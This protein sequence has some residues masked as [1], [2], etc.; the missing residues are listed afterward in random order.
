MILPDGN[1]GPGFLRVMDDPPPLRRQ[2]T[3]DFALRVGTIVRQYAPTDDQNITRATWEYDVEAVITDGVGQPTLITY[4]HCI[5]ASMFGSVGDY[6]AYAPRISEKQQTADDKPDFEGR[7]QGALVCLLAPNGNSAQ[8]AV[9]IGAAQHPGAPAAAP[10]FQN[11]LLRFEYNG[12]FVE[13]NSDGDLGVIRKGATKI[14]GKPVKDNDDGKNAEIRLN[15]EGAVTLKT[16]DGKQRLHLDL[17]SGKVVVDADQG[18]DINVTQGKLKTACAQGV[19]LGGAAEKLIKGTTYQTAEKAFLSQLGTAVN[20]LLGGFGTM[21]GATDPAV[22][23]AA[24]QLAAAAGAMTAAIETFKLQL[25]NVLSVK[26]T[27]E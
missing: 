4:P 23:A 21:A 3:T 20:Q 15:K 9:I 5:M 12:L 22:I 6:F 25:E 16:G 10:E 27:T 26:N 8:A 19:E 14:D 1:T 18:V 2:Y 11:P 7:L 24:P 17:A 13:I